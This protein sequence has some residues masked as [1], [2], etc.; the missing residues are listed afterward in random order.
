MA[1]LKLI[2]MLWWNGWSRAGKFASSGNLVSR[3]VVLWS[4][5]QGLWHPEKVSGR[6]WN[7]NVFTHMWVLKINNLPILLH[8]LNPYI[9]SKNAGCFAFGS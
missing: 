2:Y 4:G 8:N 7:A 5:S 6:T 9:C 3:P 1:D